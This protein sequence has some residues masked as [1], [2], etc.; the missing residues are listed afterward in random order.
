MAVPTT[1]R[2][3][4]VH[5]AAPDFV[6]AVSLLA[7]LEDATGQAEHSTVLPFLGMARAELTDFGQRR[8]A[9]YV[10][11]Q[12]GDLRSGLADL[13]RRLT[14]LLE[15][16]QVLQHSLRLDS[17]RRLL[18]RGVAAAACPRLESNETTSMH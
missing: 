4:D 1:A 14:A 11:V 10:P 2:S 16:S 12:V 7:A 5:D 17:A 6:Y 15:T 8:T 13:E 3:G 9:S 18:R